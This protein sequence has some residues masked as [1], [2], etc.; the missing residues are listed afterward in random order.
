MVCFL[1]DLVIGSHVLNKEP[2]KP[3]SPARFPLD[4]IIMVLNN[5]GKRQ[6]T[7]LSRTVLTETTTKAV[8][9]VVEYAISLHMSV[10]VQV[11]STVLDFI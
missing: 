2:E 3:V 11:I 1:K 8:G 9:V 7:A 5:K 6:V 10:K 4:C